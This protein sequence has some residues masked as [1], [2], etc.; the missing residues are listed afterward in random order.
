MAI[1][2]LQGSRMVVLHRFEGL[3]STEHIINKL[4]RLMDRF[5][6]QLAGARADSR[7]S[8]RLIRE[9]QDAAYQES[10]RADREKARRA[11]EEQERQRREQEELERQE[12]ERLERIEVSS[13]PRSN[14]LA[15]PHA[16]A[17]LLFHATQ[18][19]K[20][21]KIEI[22]AALPAEPAATDSDLAKLG[23][24]LPNGQRL[25]R[26]F[27][28]DDTVQLLCDFIETHDLSPLDLETDFVVVT[29]FPRKVFR[30]MSQTL[31]AAGLYPNAS[32]VVEERIDDD[33]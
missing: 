20:Q 8:A 17:C 21:R 23:I 19:R 32:I 9:Q 16:L 25:I 31:R 7:D 1:I 18:R 10:L 28:A 4:R 3:L 13:Q 33:L 29:P 12:R 14:G 5:D 24:R 26:R 22:A 30:D 15:P 2:A 6:P 27:R 11:Q